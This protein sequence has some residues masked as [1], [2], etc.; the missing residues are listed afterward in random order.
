[1]FALWSGLA[2]PNTGARP[3]VERQRRALQDIVSVFHDSLESK[4]APDRML[5]HLSSSL[6]V[7]VAMH[8]SLPL[9]KGNYLFTRC[10][11]GF[12]AAIAVVLRETTLAAD[13][14]L[15]GDNDLCT[16]LFLVASGHVNVVTHSVV[17]KEQVRGPMPSQTHAPAALGGAQVRHVC[18][19]RACTRCRTSRSNRAA[20]R[21]AS[22]LSSS[23]CATCAPRRWASRLQRFLHSL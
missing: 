11:S 22:S 17:G 3:G 4:G 2:R 1:M 13:E 23:A 6:Q 12:T 10:S 18:M 15:F 7:E 19:L 14:V 20:R 16:D 21:W 5:E 8:L 9:L